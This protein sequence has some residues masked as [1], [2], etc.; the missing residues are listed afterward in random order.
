[1]D[2]ASLYSS[3][4]QYKSSSSSKS[5]KRGR[6]RPPLAPI[7]PT[8]SNPAQGFSSSVDPLSNASLT[9]PEAALDQS[10]DNGEDGAGDAMEVDGPGITQQDTKDDGNGMDGYQLLN[11]EAPSMDICDQNLLED[12]NPPPS[13]EPIIIPNCHPLAGVWKGNFSVT[14]AK[15]T[16][17]HFF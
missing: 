3:S 8:S 13:D 12:N 14:T 10:K 2:P 1:M 5:K 11:L 9:S 6:G 7:T 15:G 17:S 4:H 16:N